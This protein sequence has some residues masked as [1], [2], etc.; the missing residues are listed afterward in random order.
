MIKKP[1]PPGEKG[2]RRTRTRSEYGKELQ[3][4]QKLKHWYNLRERQFR[5]YVKEVLDK[6]GKVEDAGALLIEKLESRLDNVVFRM[7]FASSRAQ[8][9]QVIS[10]GHF[11]INEKKVNIPS[12][13]VKKGDKIALNSESRK[14]TVF[15]NLSTSLK[16]YNPP[17][18]IKLDV[19]KLE[20]KISARPS[21][22]E[23]S[24]PAEISAIFEF[25][26]R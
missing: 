26:S 24:P 16:K 20:G 4:K 17:S 6:R 23:A 9:R 12:Y 21:L 2:K 25:Y 7:G 10:H 13:Q 22:E 1:Y 14:K 15:K 19:E 3:E 5:K 18:W 8:A 11:L